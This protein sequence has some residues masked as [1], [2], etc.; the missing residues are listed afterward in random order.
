MIA[1]PGLQSR[2]FVAVDNPAHEA[3]SY[4]PW[5]HNLLTVMLPYKLVEKWEIP[6]QFWVH[7]R[8]SRHHD[9]ERPE[10]WFHPD[11]VKR[12]GWSQFVEGSW[13]WRVRT[14]CLTS[15]RTLAALMILA[16]V[17]YDVQSHILFSTNIL[18]ASWQRAQT[19]RILLW[20]LYERIMYISGTW[21][22][23][24]MT[25]CSREEQG[26]PP[27]SEDNVRQCCS[28]RRVEAIGQSKP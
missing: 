1:S 22:L 15:L 28:K 9:F 7:C 13:G 5:W 11:A 4:K 21:L 3:I 10:R 8:E 14:A 18:P 25:S 12:T 6:L 23:T 19:I 2:A 26:Q 16:V 17:I 20:R 24:D 27:Q